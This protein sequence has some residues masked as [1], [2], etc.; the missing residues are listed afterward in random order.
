MTKNY[1]VVDKATH[2]L[3]DIGTTGYGESEVLYYTMRHIGSI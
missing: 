2:Q 3:G 1:I